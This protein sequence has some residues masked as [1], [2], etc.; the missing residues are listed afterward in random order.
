M[1]L[2]GPR[3]VVSYKQT[4]KQKLFKTRNYFNHFLVI[5]TIAIARI[6]ASS[7]ASVVVW[8]S[9]VAENGRCPGYLERY[10]LAVDVGDNI[11]NSI[12]YLTLLSDILY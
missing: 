6:A 12:G 4:K 9:A 5:I 11:Y 10:A 1:Y 7:A 3:A 8:L 2:V